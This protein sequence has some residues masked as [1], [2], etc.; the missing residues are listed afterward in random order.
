MNGSDGL[1]G[2]VLILAVA[3]TRVA[4]AFALVPVFAPDTLPPLVRNSV[5]VAFAI[6]AL[7]FQP[8]AASLVDLTPEAWAGLFA[9][10]ALIG[11][12]IGFFFSAIL[13]AFEAAGQI[14]DLKVGAS[15]AQLIDPLSGHDTSLNG[16]FLGR[17]ANFVFMFSGGLLLLATV[18]LESYAIWPLTSTGPRFQMAG[19]PLVVGEFSRLMTL[20]VLIAAPAVIVLHLVESGLGLINRFAPELNVFSLSLSIKS[21]LATLVLLAT[22]STLVQMLL[23][24]TL[25]RRGVVLDLLRAFART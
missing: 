11:L 7:A 23:D 5:F 9:R 10:E 6:M 19:L 20:A 1:Y 14:I 16:A 12:L 2:Q 15:L 3:I 18:I 17:L 21:W 24:D 22:S 13:W 8:G 25:S 4:T